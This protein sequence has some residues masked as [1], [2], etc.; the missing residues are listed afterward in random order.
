[1]KKQKTDFVMEKQASLQYCTLSLEKT[2]Q[3]PGEART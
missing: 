3:I 1:M 2:V